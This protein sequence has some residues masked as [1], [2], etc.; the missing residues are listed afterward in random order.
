MWCGYSSICTESSQFTFLLN[1]LIFFPPGTGAV[2][3]LEG[4]VEMD[5]I[6]MEGGTLKVGKAEFVEEIVD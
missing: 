6:I 4:E 3:N 5:A 1:F 2:L